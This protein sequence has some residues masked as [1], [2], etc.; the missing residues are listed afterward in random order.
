[1]EKIDRLGWAAGMSFASYGLALGVRTNDPLLVG[2]LAAHLPYGWR[3]SDA[4]E[5]DTLFS[6]WSGGAG[7]RPGVRRYHLVYS[8][9]ERVARTVDLDEAIEV[10]DGEVRLH[11]AALARRRVFVHAGVVGWRG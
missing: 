4:R 3:P 2:R 5:V 8:D 11:V 6:F 7:E 9:A 1:M 10:F